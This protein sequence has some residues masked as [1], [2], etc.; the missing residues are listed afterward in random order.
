MGMVTGLAEI[1]ADI[2]VQLYSVRD[3][4]AAN[5]ER[6]LERIARLGFTGVE[7]AGWA[8][9]S[10]E[11]WSDLLLQN[12]LHPVAMHVPY[13]NL[14]RNLESVVA[15]SNIIGAP[16]IVLP[17]LAESMRTDAQ[18]WSAMAQWMNRVG[19]EIRK[20]GKRFAYH[21]HSFEFDALAAGGTGYDRLIEETDPA[22]V[23]FELDIFWAAKAGQ[24]VPQLLRRLGKRLTLCHIKDMTGD[25]E[26]TFAPV[27]HGILPWADWLP[28]LG[29]EAMIV[30]Q[31]VCK[32]PDPFNCLAA[33]IEYLNR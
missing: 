32:D 3:E 15:E 27:G 30:E 14:D 24:D 1:T 18:A 20:S 5:L 7:L 19:A 6:S 22:L 9:A 23:E 26:R 16:V 8:S 4:I 33:S 25:A 21:N 12:R 13:E 2:A 31:D 29:V 28:L 10:P 17:F 11:R